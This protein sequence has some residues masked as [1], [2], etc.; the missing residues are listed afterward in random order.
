MKPG[1]RTFRFHASHPALERGVAVI[2][3]LVVVA[4]VASTASGL[5]EQQTV[6]VKAL[7]VERDRAQATWLLRAGLDW[8][9]LVLFN[10]GKQNAV[11][12]NDGPW[13]QPLVGLELDLPGRQDK[14]T[15]SGH[16]EDEQGKFNLMRLVRANAI[17][18][19]EL[20]RFERLLAWLSLPT[21]LATRIAQHLLTNAH[22]NTTGRDANNTVYIRAVQDL[23]PASSLTASQ[24]AVL[25]HHTTLIGPDASLN[26]NTASAVVLSVTIEGLSIGQAREIV[27]QRER[28]QWFSS[29]GDLLNRLNLSA[30]PTIRQLLGVNS[31]WFMTF[32]T[33]SLD[34]AQ[35]QM[36]AL[37]Y[38][39]LDG[40][41]VV[42]WIKD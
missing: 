30:D 29:A 42:R 16:I 18:K 13:A 20:A 39:P 40:M 9:R 28:G 7:E 41:P 1:L 8:A 34:D 25:R 23:I 12:R 15:F 33:A 17:Q 27:E 4:A 2:G 5:L 22:S 26:I 14:A 11:T 19:D 24:L 10:D 35:R 38:R 32:G 37:V 36:Q 3:A 21:E 6:D 31:Q